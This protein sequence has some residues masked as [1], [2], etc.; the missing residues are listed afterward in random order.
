M[1]YIFMSHYAPCYF[2]KFHYDDGLVIKALDRHAGLSGLSQSV[3]SSNPLGEN[4]PYFL[5]VNKNR[6]IDL[7][8]SV[9]AQLTSAATI[10]NIIIYTLKLLDVFDETIVIS[11]SRNGRTLFTIK[12][13]GQAVIPV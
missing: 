3:S 9:I 2:L 4:L 10:Q 12:K 8:S 13:C 7:S 5:F 1:P 11:R 6:R